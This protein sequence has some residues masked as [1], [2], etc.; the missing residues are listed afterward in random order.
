[1]QRGNMLMHHQTSVLRSFPPGCNA[2][3]GRSVCSP[4]KAGGCIHQ[5][6][7][8]CRQRSP[9][10]QPRDRGSLVMRA[11]AASDSL[12]RGSSS[13]LKLSIPFATEFGDTVA[14]VSSANGWSTAEVGS[15]ECPLVCLPTSC[16]ALVHVNAPISISSTLRRQCRSGGL[17]VTHGMESCRQRAGELTLVCRACH[18]RFTAAAASDFVPLTR[19]PFAAV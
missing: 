19:L 11:A 7:A 18:L 9:A 3:A 4:A 2:A 1:M 12:K 14:V 8:F 5:A 6:K 13:L 10:R 16:A 15:R 17:R